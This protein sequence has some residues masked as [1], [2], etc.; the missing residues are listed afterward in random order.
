MK[1]KK[2]DYLIVETSSNNDTEI[3][4]ADV[5]T[6]PFDTLASA[7]MDVKKG[8]LD[9]VDSSSLDLTDGKD[10]TWGRNYFIVQVVKIVRPVPVA[11]IEMEIMEVK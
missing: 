8:A 11:K 5:I 9:T 3:K 1:V 2:G 7:I 4:D 10:K 6:T